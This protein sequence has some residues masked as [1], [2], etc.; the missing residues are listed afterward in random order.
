MGETAQIM[1]INYVLFLL[2]I[3]KQ[4]QELS[5]CSGSRVSLPGRG[6]ILV[7]CSHTVLGLR[8]LFMIL[9]FLDLLRNSLV[10]FTPYRSRTCALRRPAW[11]CRHPQ[12]WSWVFNSCRFG[13]WALGSC[14][15]FCIKLFSVLCSP[16]LYWSACPWLCWWLL[17]L[18]PYLFWGFPPFLE[19]VL[20]VPGRVLSLLLLVGLMVFV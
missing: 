3:P 19:A 15:M 10:P 18:W 1:H 12:T 2:T 6:H 20:E 9:P 7:R 17:R 5:P 11:L 8:T 16:F 4:D 13:N 14:C